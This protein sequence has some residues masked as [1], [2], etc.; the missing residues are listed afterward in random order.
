MLKSFLKYNG[1]TIFYVNCYDIDPD[2]LTLYEIPIVHI[3]LHGHF[4]WGYFMLTFLGTLEI[5][6]VDSEI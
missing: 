6:L 3:E 4:V 2:S 5:F 1:I